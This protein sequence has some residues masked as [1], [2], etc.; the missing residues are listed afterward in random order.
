MWLRKKKLKK[1]NT[2]ASRRILKSRR[3][4]TVEQKKRWLFILSNAST[5]SIKKYKTYKGQMG[6]FH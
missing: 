4:K 3:I 2:T 6:L 5:F 1:A